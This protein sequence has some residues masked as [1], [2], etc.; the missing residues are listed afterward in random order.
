MQFLFQTNAFRYIYDMKMFPL[1]CKKRRKHFG[2]FLVNVTTVLT[3]PGLLNEVHM[4][5]SARKEALND[6][7]KNGGRGG[8]NK[9]RTSNVLTALCKRF[10]L[11]IVLVFLF[12]L[13]QS[14]LQG[15]LIISVCSCIVN[16]KLSILTEFF[17]E[18]LAWCCKTK[19]VIRCGNEGMPL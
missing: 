18:H 12:T 5:L 4:V 3:L 16:T 2:F 11:C 8:R 10:S 6:N 17:R 7:G 13:I 9:E 14:F 19:D 15:Q 1:W